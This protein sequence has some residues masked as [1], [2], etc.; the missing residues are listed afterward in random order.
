MHTWSNGSVV[1]T[2]RDLTGMII[3]AKVVV[4]SLTYTRHLNTFQT[5]KR[6]RIL[7]EVTEEEP[8][9]FKLTGR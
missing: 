8:D 6:M 4:L 5:E 7:I 2:K 1:Q 9:R 3:H